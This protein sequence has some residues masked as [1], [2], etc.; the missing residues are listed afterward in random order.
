MIG[1]FAISSGANEPI[2]MTQVGLMARDCSFQ[3][4]EY[5]D[6]LSLWLSLQNVCFKE[7]ANPYL[8]KRSYSIDSSSSSSSTLSPIV[9]GSICALMSVLSFL[10]GYMIAPTK[11]KYDSMDNDS[12]DYDDNL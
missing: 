7:N 4:C 6:A 3:F 2:E 9:A 11:D 1:I 5:G 8:M 12:D 10:A